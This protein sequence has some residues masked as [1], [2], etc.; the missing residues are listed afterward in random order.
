MRKREGNEPSAQLI[1]PRE[2]PFILRIQPYIINQTKT[3]KDMIPVIV[4]SK[5]KP[6]TDEKK[7]YM[8]VAPTV[9]ITLEQV[10]RN[11]SGR[12][13]V[14][15]TD[16]LAV[17]NALQTEIITA[18]LSGN[19]VRLGQVGSF[20]PT[21]SSTG[22]MAAKDVTVDSVRCV[23]CVRT[24]FT[25]GSRLRAALRLN[26][27]DVRFLVRGSQAGAEGEDHA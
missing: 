20:R 1:K 27:P 13:T 26:Q 25:P 16:C 21:V 5:K 2:I 9:S 17:L 4:V 19:S 15:E 23:R 18:M 22:E 3:F 12:C 11:I 14:T 24:R 6:G 10:A 7:F 8:Q